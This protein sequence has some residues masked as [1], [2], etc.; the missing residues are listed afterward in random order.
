MEWQFHSDTPIYAQLV[1]GIALRI[2]TGTYGPGQRLPAVRELAMEA[3]V[4]PNT[5]QRALGELERRGLVFSQRTSGRFVTEDTE[6]IAAEKRAIAT[7]HVRQLLRAM[8]QLGL[9]REEILALL[10]AQEQEEKNGNS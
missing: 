6:R 4:N 1:E 8:D 2:V 7:G 9:E 3:G 10:A 5:M